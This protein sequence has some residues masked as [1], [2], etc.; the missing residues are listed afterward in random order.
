[1]Q[2]TKVRDIITRLPREILTVGVFRDAAPE[3]VLDVYQKVSARDASA[4]A[5]R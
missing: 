3:Q 1:V 5:G 2:A 4:T